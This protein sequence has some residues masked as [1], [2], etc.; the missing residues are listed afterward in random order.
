MVKHNNVLPNIHLRKHTQRFFKTWFNQPARK[1]RRA[2]TRQEKAA[3]T[4]PRP[5]EKLRP[6]VHA[7]TRKYNS[8]LRYGRGFTLQEIKKAGLTAKFARTIGIAVDHRRQDVSEEGLQTNV[9]RLEAYKSKLIL[10]PKKAGKVKKG[11]INDS[12]AERV[13]SAEAGQQNVTKHVF[14]KPARKLREK[15]QKIT[16]EMEALK[17]FRKLRQARVNQRYKGRREKKAREQAEKEAAGPS[18]KA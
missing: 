17:A 1:H 12:T 14:E 15:P 6:V 13:K 3:K 5:L 8:K 18:K 4:F 11:L 7:L 16:K 2:I 10:F 9:Q